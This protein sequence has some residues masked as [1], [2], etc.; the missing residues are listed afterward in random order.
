MNFNSSSQIEARSAILKTQCFANADKVLEVL[1]RMYSSHIKFEVRSI[2]SSKLL[3][4]SNCYRIWPKI[5]KVI[6]YKKAPFCL[7]Y[8]RHISSECGSCL[9]FRVL[10]KSILDE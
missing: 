2:T 7:S 1:M 6:L 9:G 8:G 3:E 4:A 5:G 10:D